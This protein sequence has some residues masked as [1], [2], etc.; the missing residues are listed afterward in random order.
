MIQRCDDESFR[1]AHRRRSEDHL[2]AQGPRTRLVADFVH[3]LRWEDL[4]APVQNQAIR[5]LL[6]LCGGAIGGSCTRVAQIVAAYAQHTHGSGDVTIIGS[7]LTASAAG[8]ALAN[9]YAASALDIDDGYRP[10]KGHPGAVVFPGILAA[11]EQVGANGEAFLTAL[12]AAYEVAMRA[13]HLL[14]TFYGFYHGTGS[15]GPIG[16]AAGAARLLGCTPE[17]IWHAM[18]VGEFHACMTPEMRSV[19]HPSMLKD[20]IGWGA[21]VGL[22]SAELAARGFTGIPSL[23]DTTDGANRRL[24]DLGHEW[25]IMRLYFKPH[26]CCRWAQPAVE[27]A[28]VAARQLGV[29]YADI[30]CVRVHT[31]EAALH[32]R[33]AAPRS[34]EEAQFSLP[35]PVACALIDGAVGPEQVLESALADPDRR[36]LAARVEMLH[37]PDS[38]A[39]FPDRALAWV[40]VE[41]VDGRCTRSGLL[42]AHGDPDAPL[43]DAERTEKYHRLVTP[44]FGARRAEELRA[45]IETL[46]SARD[47]RDLTRFLRVDTSASAETVPLAPI[48]G[49]PT[50]D[51]S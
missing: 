8:A 42:A 50:R 11:A 48:A 5:V 4:P 38:E 16:A 23:F 26:A 1:A 19:D 22:A 27:G 15:W 14:H 37:D 46:P 18:G 3:T 39:A 44:V 21:M 9:G 12:V 51:E 41:T 40:E 24:D 35:W 10:L 13:G 20:G 2:V 34:T 49:S 47:I 6:D 36:A 43:T 25:L 31:F 45:T 33:N 28:C 17:Q 32:L 29:A 30:A 7:S